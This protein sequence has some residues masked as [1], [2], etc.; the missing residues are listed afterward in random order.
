[1]PKGK[2]AAK[3][4]AKKYWAED[5]SYS[6][7]WSDEDDAFVGRVLEFPSHTARGGSLEEALQGIHSLVEYVLGE[8]ASQGEP[9]PVPFSKRQFSGKLVVRIPKDLHRQLTIESEREGVS[10][11]NWI[12]IKLARPRSI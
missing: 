3:S 12:N 1:M 7:M 11:N 5:Y 8:L 10:L 6:V 4:G 2:E 9:I